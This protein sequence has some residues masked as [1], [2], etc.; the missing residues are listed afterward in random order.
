MINLKTDERIDDLQCNGYRIIQNG[1]MFCFGMDAVLL[2]NFVRHKPGARYID[3][4]TGT[5]VIPLLLAAKDGYAPGSDGT[6]TGDPRFIGVEIQKE[7]AEMASRSVLLND[8]AHVVRIDNGDI[9]EVGCNYSKASFDVVTSNPPYIKGDHGLDNPYEA[10]N[11]ARHEV[12]VT[13]KD[14]VA[15]AAHLLKPGGSFYMVHSHSG[16][17][18]YLQSYRRRSWSPRECSL[19]T[20]I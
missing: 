9:K 16:L 19:Y 5:G 14:V 8:V 15:A 10:K 18:R 17:Q 13:L 3:L 11:I 1:K 4:G 20:R 6:V 12:L 7:C 2:A